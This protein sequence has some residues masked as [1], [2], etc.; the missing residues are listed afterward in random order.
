[1]QMLKQACS[2]CFIVVGGV[3]AGGDQDWVRAMPTNGEMLHGAY[4]QM[5][6]ENSYEKAMAAPKSG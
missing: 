4:M 2:S 3:C 5:P 1:M 6:I